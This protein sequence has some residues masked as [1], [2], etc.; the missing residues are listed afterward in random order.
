MKRHHHMPFGAECRDDG[1]V[2]FPVMG[3]RRA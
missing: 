3:S 1:S 2:A